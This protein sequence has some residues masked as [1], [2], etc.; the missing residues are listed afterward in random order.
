M[1]TIR[2]PTVTAREDREKLRQLE[3]YLRYLADT[4]NVALAQLEN[5]FKKEDTN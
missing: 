5:E 1:V 3:H 2:Y 4:L